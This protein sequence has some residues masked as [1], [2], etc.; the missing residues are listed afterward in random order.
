MAKQ[1]ENRNYLSPIGFKFILEHAPKVDFTCNRINLPGINFGVAVQ[2][3][4]L[5]MIDVPGDHLVYE[6]LSLEF[7]VD[8]NMENYLE[9]YNWMIGLG[10]PETVQQFSDLQSQFKKDDQN[11]DFP[12]QSSASLLILNSNYQSSFKINYRGVFPIAL[13]PLEFDA[14]ERDYNYFT[15]RV[16][17]KYTMF[18][19]YDRIGKRLDRYDA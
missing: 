8:E 11:D 19:I 16:T 14:R 13:S 6:D 4:Y 18:N 2:P 1:L 9:I 5:K 12:E 10:Y 15:A 7:L 3:N 17:F